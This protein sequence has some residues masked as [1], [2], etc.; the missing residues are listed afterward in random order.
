[1]KELEN[2][3]HSIIDDNVECVNDPGQGLTYVKYTSEIIAIEI[4]DIAIEFVSFKNSKIIPFVRN[5][6]V[7]ATDEELFTQFIKE[8]YRK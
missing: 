1:M 7:G 8:K 3:I 5:E 6:W 2:K 4:K